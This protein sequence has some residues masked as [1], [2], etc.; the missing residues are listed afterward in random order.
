[1]ELMSNPK[2]LFLDKPTSSLS[3]DLDYEIMELLYNISK[4]GRTV[5]S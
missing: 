1:M 2:V 3:T 5:C 4:K